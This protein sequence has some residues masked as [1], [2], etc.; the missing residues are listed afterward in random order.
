M[1][2]KKIAVFCTVVQKR[3]AYSEYAKFRNHF[4][5][6][7]DCLLIFQSWDIAVSHI[8]RTERNVDAVVYL[9]AGG[10][11]IADAREFAGMF[12]K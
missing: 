12:S 5:A 1:T 3:E 6:K 2:R 10:A 8:A 9:G 7:L 4:T 11:C